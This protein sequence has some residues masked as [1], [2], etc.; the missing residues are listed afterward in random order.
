MGSRTLYSRLVSC[1][2]TVRQLLWEV[3]CVPSKV[4]RDTIGLSRSFP[5]VM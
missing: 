3:M 4:Y 2:K 1:V 5:A